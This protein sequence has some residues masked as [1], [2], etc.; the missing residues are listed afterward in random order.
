MDYIT[1]LTCITGFTGL[2]AIYCAYCEEKQRIKAKMLE[3][4]LKRCKQKV[5]E[6]E[7]IKKFSDLRIKAMEVTNEN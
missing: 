6:L 2:L 3:C 4:E 1:I 5:R 7:H